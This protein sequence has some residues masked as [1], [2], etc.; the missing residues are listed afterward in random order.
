MENFNKNSLKSAVKQYGTFH[1]DGKTD[2]EVKA[3]IAKDDRNFTDV[4]IDEIYEAIL[5]PAPVATVKKYS[6]TVIVPF[7]CITDFSKEIEEGKD[8]SD[9]EQD[10]LNVLVANGY[11]E[12]EEA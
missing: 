7:R 2:L 8:V 3:E 1:T 11:V 12:K 5:N 6:Y 10:R 9:F 4:Q